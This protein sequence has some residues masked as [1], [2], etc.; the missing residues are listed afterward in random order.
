[1]VFRPTL[2]FVNQSIKHTKKLEVIVILRGPWGAILNR[3]N[4]LGWMSKT[5]SLRKSFQHGILGLRARAGISYTLVHALK[6]RISTTQISMK[7][8]YMEI[9]LQVRDSISCLTHIL[10]WIICWVEFL[11]SVPTK[12]L[13]RTF[14]PYLEFSCAMD[15]SAVQ[16]VPKVQKVKHIFW[17]C[18]SLAII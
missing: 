13:M 18:G 14:F 1:M 15:F 8:M 11:S 6:G 3:G 12:K 5:C 9:S 7:I 17:S 16:E 4:R 10:T 2:L